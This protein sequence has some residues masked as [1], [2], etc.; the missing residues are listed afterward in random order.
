MQKKRKREVI[1]LY[2]IKQVTTQHHPR[3]EIVVIEYTSQHNR[4][5]D[6]WID[7]HR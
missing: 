1:Q 6:R 3:H 2:T 4:Q 5:L 7:T